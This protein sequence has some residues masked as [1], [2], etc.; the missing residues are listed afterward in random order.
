MAEESENEKDRLVQKIAYEESIRDVASIIE[1]E[2][3]F[4]ALYFLEADKKTGLTGANPSF[5]ELSLSFVSSYFIFDFV[6]R[7]AMRYGMTEALYDV[8]KNYT[9]KIRKS[10]KS[11]IS[12]VY[13]K[14][15]NYLDSR[16][17]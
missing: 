16:R 4:L 2:S 1:L 6:L 9:H 10:I 14:I 12:S 8:L 11:D 5:F 13:K 17:S 15:R 7:L 3:G